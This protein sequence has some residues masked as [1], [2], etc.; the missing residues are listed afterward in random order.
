[1]AMVLKQDGTRLSGTI[2]M[3]INQQ[4]DR[5]DVAFEGELSAGVLTFATK[6]GKPML[7]F[8]ASF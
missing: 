3:P 5:R 7:E 4:G 6:E 8:A 1:M 2:A